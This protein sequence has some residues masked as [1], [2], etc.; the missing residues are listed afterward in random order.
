[1]T[2]GPASLDADTYIRL[3]QD[4]HPHLVAY[5]RTLIGTP[6]PAEDAV[7]E[8]YFLVWRRL[9]SGEAVGDVPA[10]LKA[11]VRDLAMSAA[12]RDRA[13][14]VSYVDLLAR[15][16]EDLPQRWAK[17]LWQAEAERQPPVAETGRRA[18]AG[19]SPAA[20]LERA[21]DGMRQHFLR[22]QPG[23]PADPACE[24]CWERLP[25]H[26]RGADSPTQAE[27]V[28][29]HV[30]GCADCRGRVERL[31][32]ADARL[33]ALVG[34]ALMA[35]LA[36]GT[37]GYLVPLARAGGAVAALSPLPSGGAHAGPAADTLKLPAGTSAARSPRHRA[38][39][40]ATRAGRPVAVMTGAGALALAGAAVAAGLVLTGGDSTGP[41]QRT[42]ASVPSSEP[43]SGV[44]SPPWGEES[45][46]SDTAGHGASNDA[47][48]GRSAEGAPSSGADDQSPS[49]P[50]PSSSASSAPGTPGAPRSTSAP[51][52]PSKGTGGGGK[53]PTKTPTRTPVTQPTPTRTQSATPKPTQSQ[54][55]TATPEPTA[56]STESPAAEPSQSTTPSESAKPTDQ[57]S[58]PGRSG[59]DGWD[60]G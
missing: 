43:S 26:V 32:A 25:E 56:T 49:L 8:A 29:V 23:S 15:V 39:R 58:A 13:Q 37:A 51:A 55:Q 6:W 16:I 20:A 60:N 9:R 19:A 38:R 50:L 27:Q 11:T 59:G 30:A 1:M 48:S 46:R 14:R 47:S 54:D 17:A 3:H 10:A 21:R 45:A 53:A 42:A 24:W 35:L 4:H 31:M 44:A 40:R 33:S 2:E 34:P 7:A 41:E 12:S 28:A 18:E 5:A 52:V 36:R 22:A 57:P